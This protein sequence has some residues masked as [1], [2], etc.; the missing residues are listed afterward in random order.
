MKLSFVSAAVMTVLSVSVMNG[1]A[2]ASVLAHEWN[3]DTT[4]GSISAYFVPSETQ[5]FNDALTDWNTNHVN[6]DRLKD[7]Y[8]TLQDTYNHMGLVTP[9]VLPI[10]AGSPE[11]NLNVHTGGSTP[12]VA[13]VVTQGASSNF[14]SDH[15][16]DVSDYND[17][18]TAYKNGEDGAYDKVM[19]AKPAYDAY[20]AEAIT[21]DSSQVRVDRGVNLVD[22]AQNSHQT[23]P[24]AVSQ[25][26]GVAAQGASQGA[27]QRPSYAGWVSPSQNGHAVNPQAVPQ[28]KADSAP[29]VYAGESIRPNTGAHTPEVET[30]PV[31]EVIKGTVNLGSLIVVE[32]PKAAPEVET[33]P[34][35]EVIKTTVDLSNLVKADAPKAAPEVETQP[36]PETIKDSVD[37]TKVIT[38]KDVKPMTS[39]TPATKTVPMETLKPATKPIKQTDLVPASKPVAKVLHET[40]TKRPVVHAQ[41]PTASIKPVTQSVPMTSLVASKPVTQSITKAVPQVAPVINSYYVNQDAVGHKELSQAI[42][43]EHRQMSAAVAGAVGIASIPSVAGKTFSMGAGVGHY[44]DQ[45]ALTVGSTVAVAENVAVKFGVSYDTQHN[46]GEGAGIAWGF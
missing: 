13:P 6:Y 30:Q 45:S 23:N 29:V 24:Q 26:T 1:V 3:S 38:L 9:V 19:A 28:V 39:L 32:T 7:A 37:L 14:W 8:D 5:R 36:V 35:P 33:Q 34:T 40:A 17:A 25:V 20:F 4:N 31:P 21:K 42:N 46:L 2:H 18:V 10:N 16:K 27:S 41:T 11:S 15:I 44:D 12:V 43:K 22:P